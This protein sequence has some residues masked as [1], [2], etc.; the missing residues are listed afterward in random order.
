M[1]KG[2]SH[3]NFELMVAVADQHIL[4][5]SPHPVLTCV[6]G[7]AI[8]CA[9]AARRFSVLAH[10]HQ[11]PPFGRLL[12]LPITLSAPPVG[13]RPSHIDFSGPATPSP[14]FY[15]SR[16]DDVS[17]KP[18]PSRPACGGR[19]PPPILLSGAPLVRATPPNPHR[20]GN[21][22]SLSDAT[23]GQLSC[24]TNLLHKRPVPFCPYLHQHHRRKTSPRACTAR[25][26]QLRPN[27]NS[28]RSATDLSPVAHLLCLDSYER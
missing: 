15:G 27:I 1:L 25:H 9:D 20:K 19:N 5:L 2:T 24:Q 16:R 3:A 8:W 6:S 23:L 18:R 11:S 21:R 22:L 28:N 14:S 26:C 10:S 12:I 7:A 17:R 13:C 4:R